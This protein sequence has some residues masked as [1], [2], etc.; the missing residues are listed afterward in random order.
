M[1]YMHRFFF[2]LEDYATRHQHTI[3]LVGSFS[4]TIA[5]IIALVTTLAAKRAAQPQLK[6]RIVQ[7]EH[8]N[9]DTGLMVSQGHDG[10]LVPWLTPNYVALLLTNVGKIPIFVGTDLFAWE[11]FAT[12]W[13]VEPLDAHGYPREGG[14]VLVGRRD[15]PFSISPGAKET[16][17]LST[18]D[19]FKDDIMKFMET[20][21]F[22]RW[23]L[24][25]FLHGAIVT[26]DGS[27]FRAPLSRTLRQECWAIARQL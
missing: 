17:L 19:E 8:E 26:Q 23:A 7:A 12:Y 14:G 18:L 3:A 20:R 5:V 27:R 10:P 13:A 2:L 15:Y 9:R 21:R 25:R 4:T 1:L 6:A 16:I 11:S 22:G 24:L